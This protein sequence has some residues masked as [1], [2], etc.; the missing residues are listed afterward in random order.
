[1]TKPITNLYTTIATTALTRTVT[2]TTV[3]TVTSTITSVI[4]ATAVVT[5]TEIDSV[6]AT[7][8]QA[9][10]SVVTYTP[11][12]QCTTGFVLRAPGPA[13]GRYIR[14]A[15]SSSSSLIGFTNDFP[16]ATVF[17]VDSKGHIFVVLSGLRMNVNNLSLFSIYLDSEND[18]SSGGYLPLTCSTASGN[19]RCSASNGN[20]GFYYCPAS[21]SKDLLFGSE[22]G[23]ARYGCS[24]SDKLVPLVVC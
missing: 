19:L 23:A 18:I 2:S 1:V 7:S 5:T 13:P 10:T 6:V 4:S 20:N 9:Q 3:I 17:N 12:P 22:A 14:S 24:A 16:G 21:G 11:E 15:S 8:T